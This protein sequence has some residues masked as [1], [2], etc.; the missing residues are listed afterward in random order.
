MPNATVFKQANEITI[1]QLILFT[2]LVQYIYDIWR[3]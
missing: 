1:M 2:N 3:N